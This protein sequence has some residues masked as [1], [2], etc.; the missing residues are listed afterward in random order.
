MNLKKILDRV[1]NEAGFSPLATY[2]ANTSVNAQ[3][4]LSLANR[5]LAHICSDNLPFQKRTWDLTLTSATEYDFPADYRE[6]D[7][8]TQFTNMRR[9]VF[10]ST[11]DTWFYFEARQVSSGLSL[12]MRIA[13]NKLQVQNPQAGV[14][15]K[16]QYFTDYIV[17]DDDG[18]TTKRTFTEDADT[19]SA[20]SNYRIEDFFRWVCCGASRRRKGLIGRPNF[21]STSCSISVRRSQPMA[22]ARSTWARLQKS[23]RM[24]LLRIFCRDQDLSSPSRRSQPS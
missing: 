13:G 7:S 22:H 17:L 19:F 1:S 16:M 6:M 8:D 14:V 11:E 10:P 24:S 21:K 5:E 15:V 4:L 23:G 18:T 20:M 9:A 3:Q 12:R 2:A